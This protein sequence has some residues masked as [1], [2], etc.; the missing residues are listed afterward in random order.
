MLH[1][2]QAFYMYR[3]T[4]LWP[5]P[6]RTTKGTKPALPQ[7]REHKGY[8][9]RVFPWPAAGQALWALCSRGVK[10]FMQAIEIIIA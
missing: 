2:N 9:R 6:E 1:K 3:V 5:Q 7:A 4:W 10:Y 8:A